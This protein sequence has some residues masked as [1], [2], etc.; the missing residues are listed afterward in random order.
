MNKQNGTAS[1]LKSIGSL[2]IMACLGVGYLFGNIPENFNIYFALPWWVGG[3]IVG[4]LFIGFSEV[5]QLLQDINN[6]MDRDNKR[7]IND[8]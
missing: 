2:I 6:K 4:I 5:I 1:T 3:F 8:K 7:E